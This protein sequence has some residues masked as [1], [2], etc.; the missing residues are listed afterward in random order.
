[1]EALNAHGV[2]TQIINLDEDIE[3]DDIT[4]FQVYGIYPFSFDKVL[5]TLKADGKKIIYDL[6]DALDLIEPTNP[7]YYNVIK[8]KGSQRE[9]FQYADHITVATPALKEYAQSKTK[10]PITIIPNCFNPNEWMFKRPQREGI[11]I[12]FAGSPTHVEDLLQVLPTIIKLQKTHD[13]R[14]LIMGFGNASYEDWIRNFRFASPPEA[15]KVLDELEKLLLQIRFEWIPYVDFDVYPSTLINMALDIGICP[16]TDTPFNRARSASK[17]M[18]YTLAGALAL[19]SNLPAYNQDPTSTLVDD[20][21][22]ALTHFVENPD[23]IKVL[24]KKNLKWIRENRN[25]N[26]NVDLLKLV[27]LS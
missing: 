1:M 12:G 13:V 18:E 16:L 15:L 24:Q 6:D 7:F 4:A 27:Y 8:D 2:P 23:E 19:A 21:D 25:I 9:I 26:L 11:R 10:A 22:K 17:A 14:F 5:K 20:W 3:S